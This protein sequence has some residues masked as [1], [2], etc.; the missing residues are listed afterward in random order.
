MKENKLLK[1]AHTTF[2]FYKRQAS[3]LAPPMGFDRGRDGVT[4]W[5]EGRVG[6]RR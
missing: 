2:P 3:I 5:D 4:G 6:G 1:G